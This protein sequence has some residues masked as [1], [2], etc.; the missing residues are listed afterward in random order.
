MPYLEITEIVLIYCNV[1]NNSYQQNSVVL[2]TFVPNKPFG[3]LLDIWL[4]NFVFK[5]SFESDFLYVKVWFR[6]Q[7]SN[8]LLTEGKINITLVIN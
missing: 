4:E 6:D 5:K 8:L 1:A 3:Q 2:Y 7:N